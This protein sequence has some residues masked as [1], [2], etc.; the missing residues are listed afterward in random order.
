MNN[1]GRVMTLRQFHCLIEGTLVRGT[2]AATAIN[3]ATEEPLALFHTATMEDVDRA[4]LSASAAFERWK[5]TSIRTRSDLLL[6]LAEIITENE[7]L[8]AHLLVQEQGKPL[9]EAREEVHVAKE[10]FRYANGLCYRLGSAQF[11][12]DQGRFARTHSPLGIVAAVVPWNYP[13]GIAAGKIAVALAAGNAVIVKPAPTTPLTTLEFARLCSDD[14]PAGLLQVLGDDGTVGPKLVSHPGIR[15]V[16]FTGSTASGRQVMEA[17]ARTLKRQSLELGGNDPA[18]VLDDADLSSAVPA[19]CQAAFFNCGQV[20]S[21]IKRVYVHESIHDEFC[22]LMMPHVEKMVVG[23]GMDAATTIGPVQNK[24]QHAKAMA[25]LSEAMRAGHPIVQASTPVGKGYFVPPTVFSRLPDDHPLVQEEQ[26]CPL[27]PIL[28][29]EDDGEAISRAN[30]TPYGLTASVWSRAVGRA[31]TIARQLDASVVCINA[32]REFAGQG[33]S[34]CKQS[35]VGWVGGE[36][37]M[38]EYLQPH[39]IVR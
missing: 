23:N 30:A 28:R 16:S 34:M 2:K 11:E 5:T 29:F 31:E 26:F 6:R 33:F 22:D 9:F 39:L 24:A 21:A 37:E 1:E 14:V 10:A 27:L 3:P 25:L 20:C 19:I 36:E 35:G 8:L 4:V 18:I 15:K 12:M 32:H 13:F 38:R 7:E 17:G